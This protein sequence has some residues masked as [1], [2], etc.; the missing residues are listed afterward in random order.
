MAIEHLSQDFT[1]AKQILVFPDH[2]VGV[3]R[4]FL[5]DDA[6]AVTIDGRKII[7]AG[8]IYPANTSSALGVVF[9]DVDV[10]Y[11][12]RNGTLIIHGFVKKAAL[13][14]LPSV[15]A[16]AALR[17]IIFMPMEAVT[18]TMSTTALAIEAS[19]AA[20]TLHTVRV[21]IDG[22]SFRPEAA[23]LANW[24]FDGESGSKVQVQ[25]IDVGP[26]GRYIDIHTKNT[27]STVNGTVTAL[28]AAAA[29]STGDVP[30]TAFNIVVVG[31]GS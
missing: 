16:K 7:K 5:K 28:P 10:T 17:N 27:A 20:N 23:T 8:T 6:A 13:P 9:Y 19:E 26:D 4:T 29:T 11:G 31:T 24:T 3:A 15:D 12:D 22:A 30:S 25:S 1:T 21:Y 2:Y 14:A 18:V